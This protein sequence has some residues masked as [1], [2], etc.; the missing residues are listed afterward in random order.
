M[1]AMLDRIALALCLM[2]GSLSLSPAATLA[3]S[4]AGTISGRVLDRDTRQPITQATVQVEGLALGGVTD[5][6]GRFTLRQVPAGTHRLRA[7]RLDY[8]PVLV[9]DVTV[10]PGRDADVLIELLP[11]AVP[12]SQVE[13]EAEAFAKP[14]DQATSSYSMSYEEI[15]RSPGAIGDVLRL[16]QSLPG[17][18][19]T[20]DQRND[21]VA[22]GGSPAENLILVDGIEVPTLNHFATQ[23]TTGGPISMLNNE[24]VRDAEF[25]A[26][27][28]PARFGER[29]SS[30]LDVRLRDGDRERWVSET[31]V[32][33]AGFGQV[34]EGP[35]GER[36]SVLATV[37]TS[38]YDLVAEAF[39]LTAVPYATNGQFKLSY[40]PSR[41]DR[42]NALH[43]FGRDEISFR[44][45]Y[46]D[47]DDAI[48]WDLD[49]GGWRMVNGATWQRLFGTWGWGTLT[50]SDAYGR[51]EQSIRDNNYGGLE[52]FRNRSE[53]GE[54]TLRY[55]LSARTARAG[56]WKAGVS[57]KRLRN[58]FSIDQPY[59]A[60]NPFSAD[61]TRVD[62][63]RV[64]FDDTAIQTAAYAQWTQA[65]GPRT[66]L[67]LGARVAHF[68]ELD[69]TSFDPRASLT[70]Q[71]ATPLDLNLSFARTHQ[72]PS[73]VFVRAVPEN[74]ALPPIESDHY[75]AG[76]SYLP[77]QD[78][79]LTLEVY[80]KEIRDYPVARDYPTFSLANSGDVYGVNG[81]LFPM[82]GEGRGRATGIE[83]FAQKKLKRGLYGQLTYGAQRVEQAALDGVYRR[84]GFDSPHTGTVI[85]GFKP[86]QAWEASTRFSYSRGRPFTPPLEPESSQQ[87]RYIY[88][89][90]R[91]NAERAP[92]YHRLD[93]RFDRRFTLGRTF[94]TLWLEVQ[95]VY[96]RENA[97]LYV[98]NAKTRSLDAVP[99]ITFL[100]VLGV[101]VEF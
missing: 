78:L 99:Q 55:D 2:L 7:W 70:V 26:G 85:V 11:E 60:E 62:R 52:I 3:Q 101:N 73:T 53:E 75:I 94:T 1:S 90:S 50:A 10:S 42:W 32:G 29:L 33:F 16:V 91:V 35:L 86:S 47:P 30:V 66:D 71:L 28:F 46:S 18:V 51:F 74:A 61:T 23:G 17:V 38:F 37:R 44:T 13:V 76:L 56:D 89:L 69:A 4:R 100:P 58:R 27:G 96:D 22:R 49:S 82:V 65:L 84:G 68:G 34:I 41:R 92:D 31:D 88:D 14:R 24:L 9:S 97:F 20:N 48:T 57:L 5:D 93:V 43:I 64:A 80:R 15:R 6:A 36:A 67:T 81:L 8:P 54:S 12:Q 40:E 72:A 79:K 25:L 87:N 83:L 95:N 21:I 77:Q 63:R 39:G 59:G 45:D 98:W 19:T